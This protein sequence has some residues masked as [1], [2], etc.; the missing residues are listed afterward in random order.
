MRI[1]VKRTEE[2][3]I[4]ERKIQGIRGDVIREISRYWEL[5]WLGEGCLFPLG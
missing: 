1:Q 2:S 4:T 5:G 3:K